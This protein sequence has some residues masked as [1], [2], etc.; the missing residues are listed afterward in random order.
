MLA[1]SFPTL[2]EGEG[3]VGGALRLFGVAGVAGGDDEVL[4]AIDHVGG[5]GGVAGE[6]QISGPEKGAGVAVEAADCVVVDR[7]G[8][9][10]Q[11][12]GG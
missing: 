5:G 9:E 3:D 10:D 12:A 1:G 4:A 8:D 2:G 11:A 6:G 7:G